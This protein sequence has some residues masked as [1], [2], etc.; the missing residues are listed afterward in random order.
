MAALL[1]K[2]PD[3][4][5]GGD[6]G[7]LRSTLIAPLLED[8]PWGLSR[9]RDVEPWLGDRMAVAAVP[10]PGAEGGVTPSSSSR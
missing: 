1:R 3:L 7:D 6:D 4:Q 8:N 10:D 9:D 5:T 2:F